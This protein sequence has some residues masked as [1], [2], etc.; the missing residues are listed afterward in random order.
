MSFITEALTND[1]AKLALSYH[2]GAFRE[3]NPK[4]CITPT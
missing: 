1:L 4:I 2:V 3:V